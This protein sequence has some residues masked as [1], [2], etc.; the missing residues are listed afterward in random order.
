M[1][2]NTYGMGLRP[3]EIF[4][5]LQS[6]DRLRRQILTTNVEKGSYL[7]FCKLADTTV[8]YHVED[9]IIVGKYL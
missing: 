8:C 6:G 9:F 2:L 3:L 4:L 5:L 7:A 1:H